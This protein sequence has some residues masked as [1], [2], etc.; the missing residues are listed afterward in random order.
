MEFERKL[1]N[2]FVIPGIITEILVIALGL[3]LNL[4]CN[5]IGGPAGMVAGVVML[6]F[7]L[8]FLVYLLIA[9]INSILLPYKYYKKSDTFIDS[10]R[11][12]LKFSVIYLVIFD[13]LIIYQWYDCARWN[14]IRSLNT[15]ALIPLTV[16]ILVVTGYFIFW[17]TKVNQYQNVKFFNKSTIGVVLGILGL[18][19]IVTILY[20]LPMFL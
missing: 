7:E 9:G 4:L 8:I 10:T 2:G 14:L 20:F 15:P 17:M 19:L 5:P 6:K 11:K 18:L 13:A 16:F 1:F 12:F 3:N